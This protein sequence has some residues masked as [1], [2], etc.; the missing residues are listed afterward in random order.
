[1]DA[2]T[3][4]DPIDTTRRRRDWRFWIAAL[5]VL[6]V[7]A[8]LAYWRFLAEIPVDYTAEIDHFKY[9]SIGSDYGGIP[10]AI[11]KVLPEMFPEYL[12]D[13]GA[14]YLKVPE[15]E[16][17]YLDGYRTFGLVVEE[18][19]PLPVGFSQRRVY[20]D[21]V[22]LNCALCHV[23][24]VRVADGMI[25][26]RI[27]GSEPTYVSRRDLNH[28]K[29]EVKS[30]L[31]AGMPANTLDL[32]AYFAFLFRCA[33]DSRFTSDNILAAIKHRGEQAHDK[34]GPIDEAILCLAVPQL[35]QTLLERRNQLHYLSLLPHASE[36]AVG[37]R[38]GP[39]RVDTFGPYKSIQFGFPYDGRSGVADYPS[40]WNQRPREGMHLHWDGNN[41]SVFE[42]NISASLGA[43]ATPVSLDLRRMLRVASWIGSP[44]PD[45]PAYGGTAEGGSADAAALRQNPFPKEGELPIPQYPF[46]VDNSRKVAGQ[47]LFAH[48]CDRC[49][50]WNGASTGQVE[51]WAKI[52]TDR[53]RLD[54]YTEGLEANQNLLG[55]GHWWRFRHF[56]KTQGYANMPLDGVWVRAPYLH[57]GSVPTLL[58]LFAKPCGEA[59]LLRLGITPATLATLADSPELVASVIAKAR[60]AGLRPPVFYRGDDRYDPVRVGFRCDRQ[61]ADDGRKLFLYSSVVVRNGRVQTQL[62][63][64]HEGHYGKYFGTELTDDEKAALL[65]YQKTLG[66][67]DD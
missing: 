58:D 63:N 29:T 11:W 60:A 10:M 9:G 23:S 43:G 52:G 53:A 27:Y 33:E 21:R 37:L 39:G 2:N 55:A 44:P 34:P 50:G 61:F 49:H 3:L 13:Q 57:N 47:T 28:P 48:Y 65:E 46:P 59:D 35:R 54:S 64:G 67:P 62:G 16:R 56:R 5:L 26:E 7:I 4:I 6:L 42:R 8:G 17:T 41:T 45:N 18:G 25:P 22:G 1:V 19:R 40:I 66:G 32:E 30:V 14:D 51:E 36:E 20:V 38:F 12:P 31:I 24:T 15:A